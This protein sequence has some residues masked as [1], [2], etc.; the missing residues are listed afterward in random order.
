VLEGYFRLIDRMKPLG[1]VGCDRFCPLTVQ[2]TLCVR[3]MLSVDYSI[4]I[5]TLHHPLPSRRTTPDQTH[6]NPLQKPA[7][8]GVRSIHQT[9]VNIR[10]TEAF[11]PFHLDPT[12]PH[13]YRVLTFTLLFEVTDVPI[14]VFCFNG[15]TSA[16]G[17][18]GKAF[19]CLC[20]WRTGNQLKLTFAGG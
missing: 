18:E 10:Q 14:T 7:P 9:T 11:I 5:H 4:P 20:V 6:Y 1:M 12:A 16:N 17:P 3:N 19:H 8:R 2:V 15:R 13:I